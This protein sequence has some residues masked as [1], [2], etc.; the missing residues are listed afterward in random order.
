MHKITQ[1]QICTITAKQLQHDITHSKMHTNTYSWIHGC[2]CLSKQKLC[3]RCLKD[4]TIYQ[5]FHQTNS[6]DAII[7]RRNTHANT[8]RTEAH[9]SKCN[10]LASAYT[11]DKTKHSKWEYK[12]TAL[13]KS[14]R[15][16]FSAR[17]EIGGLHAKHLHTLFNESLWPS[18]SPHLP[19]W[20]HHCR[21]ASLR[22]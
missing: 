15:A 22:G 17:S 4:D 3:T 14:K 2:K 5:A 16:I 7:L 9:S 21:C 18:G 20:Q 11:Q 6:L 8:T 12:W 1:Y 10:M 13:K 19:P